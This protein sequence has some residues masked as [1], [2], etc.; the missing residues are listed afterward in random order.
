M[1]FCLV[2]F[3]GCCS[4]GV[5]DLFWCYCVDFQNGVRT[6]VLKPGPAARLGIWLT[7]DWNQVGLKKNKK[8]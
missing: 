7:R 3:S 1:I 2:Y 8:N 6:K 4:K 5:C